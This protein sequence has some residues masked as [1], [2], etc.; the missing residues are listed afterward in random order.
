MSRARKRKNLAAQKDKQAATDQQKRLI[1]V[2]LKELVGTALQEG[3]LQQLGKRRASSIINEL[4]DVQAKLRSLE[5]LD[6]PRR[7]DGDKRSAAD[8]RRAWLMALALWRW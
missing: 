3:A 1:R 7:K 6:M 8:R 4:Q 2:L 5:H